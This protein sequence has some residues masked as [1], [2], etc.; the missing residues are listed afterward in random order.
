MKLKKVQAVPLNLTAAPKKFW[1]SGLKSLGDLYKEAFGHSPG[2]YVTGLVPSGSQGLRC[3]CWVCLGQLDQGSLVR[4]DKQRLF[5]R[6]HPLPFDLHLSGEQPLKQVWSL[7]DSWICY[8]PSQQL[9]SPHYDFDFHKLSDEDF[10]VNSIH[11]ALEKWSQA[12]ECAV[13]KTIASQH[14]LEPEWHPTP[15]LP[16]RC[17]GRCRQAPCV[18]KPFSQS[19]KQAWGWPTYAKCRFKLS[20]VY[21]DESWQTSHWNPMFET[22]HMPWRIHWCMA[23]LSSHK[24]LIF[25][26][27]LVNNL[28]VPWI[29]W[30]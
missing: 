7:H 14:K 11:H 24:C 23:Y 8:E 9:L 16:R 28:P 4:L 30:V 25:I 15:K 19:I 5:A 22:N 21:L 29:L 17:K 18:K 26:F 10:N 6:H 12:V 20:R 3:T 1:R 13:D 2:R 27:L